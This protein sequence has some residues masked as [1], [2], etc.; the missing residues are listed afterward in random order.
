MIYGLI[1]LYLG[2]CM[3]L[4]WF[5]NTLLY[6][7]PRLE[8]GEWNK[9]TAWGAQDAEFSAADGTKL[10]GWY[11]PNPQAKRMV[12]LCHGNGENTALA[13][14]EAI[15]LRD[16]LDASVLV[17]D[18]RGYGKSEGKPSEQGLYQDGEAAA[19]W[20]AQKSGVQVS[21]LYLVGRSLGT[22]VAVDIGVKHQC[23]ALILIS[24]YAEI[25]DAAAARFWFVPVRLLMRNRY[26]SVKKIPQFKGKTFIAHG[27][28]DNVV[29]H[30]SGVRLFAATP[31]TKMFVTVPNAGHND[32]DL[33]QCENVLKT[34]LDKVE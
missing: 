7:A 5:E 9:R 6:P 30:W 15:W 22:G 17:W 24:P 13:A 11:F 12:L 23:K 2:L 8:S 31:E 18:Y 25:P 32:I 19:Q 21:E 1:G 27:D 20:L 26:P 4:M 14:R 16:N 34:F 33:S 29:P 10:H 28:K 3:L